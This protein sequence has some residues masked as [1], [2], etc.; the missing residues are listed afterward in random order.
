MD[1]TR[2]FSTFAAVA[3]LS[4]AAPAHAQTFRELMED[5][6]L[7]DRKQEKM[8]FS[9]RAPLVL[10]P[11]TDAAALP[12]P[13]DGA[14]LAT[15]NPNWPND[16]DVQAALEE[17]EKEKIPERQRRKYKEN[18]ANEIYKFQ[19]QERE[20]G[21]VAAA[22]PREYDTNFDRNKVL[23]PEQLKEVQKREAEMAKT[24]A[25]VAAIEPERKRLT[26]P[27]PGYRTPSAEQAYGPGEGDRK[28]G[29]FSRVNPFASNSSK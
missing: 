20:A 21:R 5:I 18:Q 28:K 1:K 2:I 12:P 22:N 25:P 10:P 8:D 29:F 13:E 16:P 24:G 26:D 4:M 15:V 7:Q 19:R 3:L 23:T 14:A 27:P 9:E 11:S 6:G 17:E